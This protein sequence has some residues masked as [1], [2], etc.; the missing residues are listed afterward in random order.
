LPHSEL[1]EPLPSEFVLESVAK[2]EAETLAHLTGELASDEAASGKSVWL[3]KRDRDKV[4][5]MVFGPY[6]HIDAGR[7]IALFRLKRLSEGK[8]FVA[9]VDTCV[10]GGTPITAERKVLAEQLPIG[11]FCLI[12]LIVHHHGGAIETRVFWTGQTDLA[13]DW[14]ILLKI[15]ANE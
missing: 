12:P 11:E 14:V 10:G 1:I 9:I 6:T 7:Y 8:G 13:V 4:G 3:A 2:F 15:H 5:H